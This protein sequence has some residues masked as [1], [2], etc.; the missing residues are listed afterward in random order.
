MYY[1]Y[2][3][4]I[5]KLLSKTGFLG[6]ITHYTNSLRMVVGTCYNGRVS[7]KKS[8]T[9]CNYDEESLEQLYAD[10][11]VRDYVSQ[12]KALDADG[13]GTLDASE[14]TALMKNLGLK[15]SIQNM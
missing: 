12:F 3:F 8:R 2:Y 1:Y 10:D 7:A 14:M 11:E 5:E 15:E 6:S 4:I 13:N 9:I